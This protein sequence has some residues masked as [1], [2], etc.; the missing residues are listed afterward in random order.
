M[1]NPTFRP[2]NPATKIWIPVIKIAI[3]IKKPTNAKP[4]AG[5]TI[6]NMAIAIDKIPTPILKNLLNLLYD[7]SPNP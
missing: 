4:K 5:D 3:P 7:F 6:I 1:S 2:L